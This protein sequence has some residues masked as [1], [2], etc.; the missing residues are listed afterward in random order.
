MGWKMFDGAGG[1]TG[2]VACQATDRRWGGEGGCGDAGG[3]AE[4]L[5]SHGGEFASNRRVGECSGGIGA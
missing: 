2:F 3:I 4:R 1:F 5:E